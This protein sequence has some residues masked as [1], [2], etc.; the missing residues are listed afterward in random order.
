MP[1]L[2]PWLLAGDEE[3]KHVSRWW[4]LAKAQLSRHDPELVLE[5]P[6]AGYQLQGRSK[7]WSKPSSGLDLDIPTA[8]AGEANWEMRIT[9]AVHLPARLDPGL[10]CTAEEKEH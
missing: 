9:W 10:G 8:Q 2:V 1:G 7:G 6:P 5:A 4:T 3:V